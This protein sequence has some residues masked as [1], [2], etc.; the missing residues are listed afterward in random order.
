MQQAPRATAVNSYDFA[1][2]QLLCSLSCFVLKQSVLMLT[3]EASQ[4]TTLLKACVQRTL[5]QFK[6]SKGMNLTYMVC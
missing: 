1:P 3:M 6:T 2:G 4:A 5:M